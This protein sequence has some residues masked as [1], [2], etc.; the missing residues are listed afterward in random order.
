MTDTYITL[1]GDKMT[2]LTKEDR[3]RARTEAESFSIYSDTRG[4]LSGW[5][6]ALLDTIEALEKKAQIADELVGEVNTLNALTD[7]QGEK[8]EDLKSLLHE[9]REVMGKI[10]L[11][12]DLMN[13]KESMRIKKVY[14]KLKEIK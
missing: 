6:L 5:I 12:S 7:S 13:N 14:A 2:K 10:P 8:I 4:R 9:V 1:R 3:E 11:R